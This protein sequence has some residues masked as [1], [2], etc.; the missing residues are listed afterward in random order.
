MNTT[1]SR[2]L[3]TALAFS[4][5]LGDGTAWAGSATVTGKVQKIDVAASKVTIKHGPIKALDMPDP[6]TMVYPVKDPAALKSIKTGDEVTFDLDQGASGY[7]VT[8]IEK[9]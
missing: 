9:K 1:R 3:A 4:L 7:L 8:R 5:L 6:M 2:L